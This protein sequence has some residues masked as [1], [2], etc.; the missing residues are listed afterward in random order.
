MKELRLL[1][2]VKNNRLLE[3]R[4]GLELSQTTMSQVIGMP[5]PNYADLENLRR[6]PVRGDS[7]T[8][9]A[10][11]VA[12]YYDCDPGDLFP[13]AVLQI[14]EPV[15]ERRVDA[16]EISPLTLSAH[17]EQLLLPPD[18]RVGHQQTLGKVRDVLATLRPQEQDLLRK[19]YGLDGQ[20][21]MTL[22]QV[23]E[24]DPH[25]PSRDR[26]RQVMQQGI[27]RMRKS[28]GYITGTT[29]HMG[30]LRVKTPTT[31]SRA[32]FSRVI[33]LVDDWPKATIALRNARD[34]VCATWPRLAR[35]SIE[36]D[37]LYVRKL[38]LLVILPSHVKVNLTDARLH[39]QKATDLPYS[40]Y[41]VYPNAQPVGVFVRQHDYPLASKKMV[42]RL[43]ED[44]R[45][46][47]FE[48][49]EVREKKR[50]VVLGV[51]D[52][53]EGLLKMRLWFC[54]R[55]QVTKLEV[56]RVTWKPAPRR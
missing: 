1:I 44:A 51:G 6:S 4:E 49:L 2:R 30:H 22:D 23:T 54:D 11:K 40:I 14:Q 38:K 25:Y 28:W 36:V 13:D 16:S 17:S 10:L 27:A 18:D 39:V 9:D 5:L 32:K 42:E 34:E 55:A 56:G 3:R 31:V 15:A 8:R 46:G 47:G 29:S 53:R 19:Y 26:V 20:G 33:D 37:P 52:P 43:A 48:V 35:M 50:E 7:W 12:E 21:G 24:S 41:T 45:A